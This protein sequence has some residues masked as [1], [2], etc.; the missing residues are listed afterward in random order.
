MVSNSRRGR[1]RRGRIHNINQ[2]IRN[3]IIHHNVKSAFA[4][5]CI[6]MC[7]YIVM[8]TLIKGHG[9]VKTF[10]P[11]NIGKATDSMP[12]LHDSSTSANAAVAKLRYDAATD[13]LPLGIHSAP[14]NVT[15]TTGVTHGD[16]YKKTTEHSSRV[17]IYQRWQGNPG[18][19]EALL[20][21]VLAFHSWMPA[22]TFAQGGTNPKLIKAHWH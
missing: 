3:R 22:R 21:L 6:C 1:I 14:H 9:S 11:S 5:W 16:N 8:N 19:V 7:T 13:L 12:A 17:V 18:G 4:L 15:H 10:A 20:Q 2:S